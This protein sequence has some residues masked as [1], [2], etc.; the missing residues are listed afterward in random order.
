MA[1]V[2]NN[3]SAAAESALA[4]LGRKDSASSKDEV[5]SQGR[6]LTLLTA[7]LKNQDPM[8]PLDN[9]Q[10]TSQLAQISTV[11]GIE[12]L[13]TMLTQ[14]LEGQ[15]S[16]ESMQA[17]SLVGRGVLVPGSGLKLGDAGSIGGFALD[18]P[19]DAVTMHIKDAQGLEVAAVDLGSFDAGT[20]N[21]QWD[22]TTLDGSRA[23][24]GKYKVSIE[25]V[26]GGKPITAEALEF[27][28]VTSVVRG[29]KG[30]DLQVGDMGIFKMSDVR[31]IV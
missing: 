19:A 28:A 22:G 7:Q 2:N 21:F 4:L 11:D 23:A 24:N 18:V 30:T 8:N 3:V 9:A 5:D 20:H 14:I 17:A 12:R 15:Q 27:G 31:Q 1:T 25:A 6:F 29:T 16:S 13:N 10:V 26:T